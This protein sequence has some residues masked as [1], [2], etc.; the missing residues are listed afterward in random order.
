M[1]TGMASLVPRERR[2]NVTCWKENYS[3]SRVPARGIAKLLEK[4]RKLTASRTTRAESMHIHGIPESRYRTLDQIFLR[5]VYPISPK[6]PPCY[7]GEQTKWHSRCVG[8]GRLG[9]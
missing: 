2:Q 4:P 9:L 5:E 6:A 3:A 1:D 7:R 8:W